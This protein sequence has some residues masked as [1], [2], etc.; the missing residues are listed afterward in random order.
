[1]EIV[2]EQAGHHA[3]WPQARRSFAWN[4][5]ARS[6]IRR[7]TKPCKFEPF[8]ISQQPDEAVR[9]PGW[10]WA[11]FW[12]YVIVG[13]LLF[14]HG[15]WMLYSS[16]DMGPDSLEPQFR[17]MIAILYGVMLPICAQ[18]AKPGIPGAQ[19]TGGYN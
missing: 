12:Y 10:K 3:R 15:A 18:L 1:M 7:A 17:L 14:L 6:R 11:Q 8:I 13:C 2:H 16:K 19:A 5:K 4:G 9:R